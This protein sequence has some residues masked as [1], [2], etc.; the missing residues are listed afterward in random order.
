MVASIVF[1][2]NPG[3]LTRNYIICL[4]VFVSVSF[5]FLEMQ[6]QQRAQRSMNISSLRII[7]IIICLSLSLPL[8]SI[9]HTTLSLWVS[10]N[11]A[12]LAIIYQHACI[13]MHI[14]LCQFSFFPSFSHRFQVKTRSRLIFISHVFDV[15]STVRMCNVHV[16]LRINTTA[17]VVV[18]VVVVVV[19]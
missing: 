3:I 12:H 18:I 16:C 15:R 19:W 6:H 10:V 4:R 14:S 13:S 2:H 1:Q 5:I 9:F 7:I 11:P 8:L 17:A